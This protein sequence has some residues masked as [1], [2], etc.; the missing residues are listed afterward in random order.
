MVGFVLWYLPV[1]LKRR[2]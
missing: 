2:H 1:M